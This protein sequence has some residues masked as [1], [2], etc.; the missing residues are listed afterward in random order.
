M[1]AV[2]RFLVAAALVM[3]LAGGRVALAAPLTGVV[4]DGE[5]LAPIAGATITAE[6]AEAGG[7]SAVTGGD[8]TYALDL[9]AGATTL[10]VA[11]S[12][13]ETL[14]EVV[15]V[16]P[17][18]TQKTLV[19]FLEG[20]VSEVIEITEKAPLLPANPGDITLPREELT[21]I[22]GTRG[23]ALQSI[24]SLPGVANVDAAGSG[25]GLVVIRGAAPE[26]SKVTIDGIE[27]PLLY[28][29][30][31]LQSIVPSEFIETID[32]L[33]GGF[34]VEEG[35]AT[36]GVIAIATRAEELQQA[37]GFAELSFINFAG[38]VQG[39]ISKRHHLQATAAV[40]RSAIDLLLPAVIPDDANLSFTTAPQ[41]YDGQLRVDWR[42][43][44]RNRVTFL[45]LLSFDLLALLNDNINP[46]E[47]LLTGAFENETSFSRGI[48][49]WQ[50]SG[51]VLQNRAVAS[52][53]TTGLRFEIGAQ[54]Y[55][56]VDQRRLELRDDLLFK[57]DQRLAVRAGVEARLAQGDIEALIPLPPSEGSGGPGNFSTAATLD[58]METITNH[59]A[60][61]YVAVD[62]QPVA[63]TL[64]TPGLRLDYY[65]RFSATTVSP[66]IALQQSLTSD[67]RLRASL[68]TYT[69]PLDQVESLQPELEPE[70]ATQYVAGIDYDLAEGLSA[71]SS[72]FY[73]DRRQLVVQDPVRADTMPEAAYINRGWGRS[74]GAEALLR[75]R[76]EQLFGWLAY[77]VS[78]S[79]RVDGPL[80]ERRLFDYDQTHVLIAVASYRW[81][82]WNFGGR[83]TLSSGNPLTPVEGSIYLADVNVYVP[84]Y[85]EVN[86][87]RLDAAHQLDL[88]IDRLWQ[89]DSWKLAAYL[90]VTNVYAN[91]RTLG[92]Q[93]N[94]DYSER[95][96][97]EELPVV[98]ALGLRGSF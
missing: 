53:G 31:G 34:G 70:T 86:E 52:V 3:V 63:G 68:G 28:H 85:G 83:W 56:R 62:F 73:T 38:L 84:V 32:F 74:F 98:P 2:Q 48:L 96:A 90:D 91:P 95:E 81:G 19:L 23:D 29:F 47:P 27:I 16:A 58:L 6:E 77:T 64:I 49:T 97:I 20:V 35:R 69:R 10:S 94:F 17:S 89:F 65:D 45:G 75:L 5:T 36:G 7:A 26:D 42:P 67:W 61:A 93:Y 92:F 66:R 87:T 57:V 80:A 76:R 46:N 24:K 33:P 51:D 60:A 21:R 82:A 18:G 79:D 44:Y 59:I 54:R 8:G 30:F 14:T 1:P 9:P 40:R 25:P 39:P 55:L 88:R 71:S 37:T 43:D 22:P 12:G 50:H 41:Y 13:Y 78:R 11:A 4:I 15:D 72:V